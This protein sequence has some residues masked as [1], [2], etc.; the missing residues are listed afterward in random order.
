MLIST[1]KSDW[2]HDVTTETG[3]LANFLNT[4]ASSAPK[5]TPAAITTNGSGAA[6]KAVAGVYDPTSTAKTTILDASHVSLSDHP[7]RDTV[8]VLPDYKIVTEVERTLEGAQR[9]W[10]EA[11][12]PAVGRAGAIPTEDEDSPSPLRSYVLPYS[13]VILLCA[14]PV[15]CV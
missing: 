11:V 8:L 3:T 10:R 12:D 15:A 6:A 13:V 4:A 14:L 7:E 9:L 1:G 2:P 5:S